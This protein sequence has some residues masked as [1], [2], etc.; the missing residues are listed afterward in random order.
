MAMHISKNPSQA[1]AVSLSRHCY[2]WLVRV[3]VLQR[4]KTEMEDLFMD[5]IP[6]QQRGGSRFVFRQGN[7][8]TAD[9]L[10]RVAAGGFEQY[11]TD[12]KCTSP[13]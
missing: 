11:L 10:K 2:V 12:T 1:V 9:D 4:R 7:P 13:M 5:A 3:C 6:P 8:L